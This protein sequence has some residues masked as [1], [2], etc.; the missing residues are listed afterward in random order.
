MSDYTD[1]ANDC[2]NETEGTPLTYEEYL[3][4]IV[5]RP[6]LAS[7]SAKYILEAIESTTNEHGEN[8]RAVLEDGELLDRWVFFDD[9]HNG[10]EHA[11]LGNTAVLNEFVRD[12]RLLASDFGKSEK[13]FWFEGPTATGKS[14]LKRCLINGLREYSKTAAG[15]RYTVEWNI[16]SRNGGSAHAY[17]GSA[18][19]NESDW[20]RSPVQAH[21]LTVLPTEAREE[22]LASLNTSGTKLD[23][24]QQ[25]DPFS[26]EAYQLL[27]THYAS[28]NGTE[29]LF[30]DVTDSRHL[31]VCRYTM[32]VGQGIGV[33]HSEDDGSPKQRLAGSW[34]RGMLQAL[35][36][37]GRKNPQAFS[38]DGLLAQGHTGLSIVED[39]SQH[40][41]L[42]QKLLNIPEEGMVKLDQKIALDIETV[43]LL[44]SNP[45]LSKTLNQHSRKDSKD[46]L[47]AL[48]RR[49]DKYDLLYLTSLSSEVELLRREVMNDTDVWTQDYSG[50]VPE[51]VYLFN[52]EIAPH[53][54]EAAAMYAVVSRLSGSDVPDDLSIVDKALIFERGHHEDGDNRIEKSEYDFDADTDGRSGMPVTF[55]RDVI[56]DLLQSPSTE[57]ATGTDV[58]NVVMPD[59]VIA[60]LHDEVRDAPVFSSGEA[61]DYQKHAELVQEYIRDR[62][63]A[64]VIGAILHTRDAS[65]DAVAEYVEH[66][67]AW[68]G[69]DSAVD[70][71]DPL[72]MKVFERDHLGR[73]DSEYGKD[74]RASESVETF[75][76]EKIISAVNRYIWR[77]RTDD[78]ALE[79]DLSDLPVLKEILGSYDWEDIERAFPDFDPAQWR[80]PSSGTETASVKDSCIDTLVTEYSYSPAS[81]ERAAA[82]VLD[83][84]DYE[85]DEGDS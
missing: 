18:P 20:Y 17:D 43:F 61:R 12:L 21:P 80:D 22:V 77:T 9:P 49:M 48:K 33:L 75:R 13:I 27:K 42:L 29:T 58:T 64:D 7:Q 57:V 45:D 52:S 82:M 34:M 76:E 31:R 74:S 56:G 65:G 1:T 8:T 37:R 23:L 4:R 24:P 41:D 32:D 55:T 40:A 5:D 67:Y 39:A 16:E 81:A 44:I 38:Y 36:S 78:Y 79:S 50:K 66:V 46:P 47:K 68:A 2:L 59:D 71:H 84:M 30:D 62:Q 6:E 60:A 69:E 72:K 28:M 14:E 73:R 63:E 83:D 25:L 54:L 70:E 15:E 26:N 10:G 51:P 53:T 3:E 35:D 85:F 11:I 19:L